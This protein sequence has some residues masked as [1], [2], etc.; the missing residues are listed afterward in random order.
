MKDPLLFTQVRRLLRFSHALLSMLALATSLAL[1]GSETDFG[2]VGVLTKFPPSIHG[3]LDGVAQFTTGKNFVLSNHGEIEGSLLVP[4][5][6]SIR[7]NKG[8]SFFEVIEGPGSAEPSNYKLIFNRGSSVDTVVTRIDPLPLSPPVQPNL[9][10]GNRSVE[11]SEYSSPQDMGDFATLENLKLKRNAGQYEIPA[12]AYGFFSVAHG[13]GIVFGNPGDTEPAV[14]HF[15]K[16]RFSGGSQLQIAGPVVINVAEGFTSGAVLGNTE[17]PE[18][19]TMNIQWGGLNIV[20]GGYFYGNLKAPNGHIN[21]SHGSIL[22]GSIEARKLHVQRHGHLVA[23]LCVTPAPDGNEAPIADSQLVETDEDMPVSVVLTASDPDGDELSYL[24]VDAPVNGILSGVAPNFEYVPNPN[25]NGSDF[26]TFVVSDGELESP[27]ALVD[28]TI[29]PANDAPEAQSLTVEV[30]EDVPVN[31]ELTG[32]DVENDPLTFAIVDQPVHGTLDLSALPQVVY[33]PDPDSENSD[34][35]TYIVN[36]G[37]LDSGPATVLISLIPVN[38]APGATPLVVDLH[39]DEAVEITLVGTDEEGDDLSFEIVTPPGHGVLELIEAQN[40]IVDPAFRYIPVANFNG[41]DH[42]TY[43]VYD[44]ELYSEPVAVQLNIEPVNDPPFADERSFTIEEDTVGTLLLTASDVDGDDLEFIVQTPPTYGEILSSGAHVTSFPHSLGLSNAVDYRPFENSNQADAFT[45][46]VSDGQTSSSSAIANIV[47]TPANDPPV[48]VAQSLATLEDTALDITLAASDPENDPLSFLVTNPPANGTLEGLAPHLT[49]IPSE[50]FDE[51]DTF[52]FVANDGELDSEPVTIEIEVQPVNDAPIVDPVELSLQEDSSTVVL[53][54][55]SDIES[56]PEDLTF[57]IE[58]LPAHGA[59]ELNGIALSQGGATVLPSGS[60]VYRP[61]EDFSD[62]DTFSY[63]ASD[64]E[65][66]SSAELVTLFVI[67]VNDPPFVE[68]KSVELFED[69]SITI[70]LEG[71]DIDGDPLT[72]EIVKGPMAG[73]I[74]GTLPEVIYTP[75]PNVYGVDRIEYRAFDGELYSEIEEYEFVVA[76]INDAPFAETISLSTLEDSTLSGQLLAIDAEGDPLSFA[77]ETPP[78][79]GSVSVEANGAFTYTPDAD[80]NGPDLFTFTVSDG[81]QTVSSGVVLTVESVN[82]A[83]T[84]VSISLSVAENE[85]VSLSLSGADVDGDTLSFTIT[86]GPSSGS[87][88]VDGDAIDTFPANLSSGSLI[89]T[90]NG[91]SGTSDT[92]EFLA[93]DGSLE[94]S[95]ETVELLVGASVN[96][97]PVVDA[98]DDQTLF[99]RS[100]TDLSTAHGVLI[101]CSDE[102]YLSNEGFNTLPSTGNFARNLLTLFADGPGAQFLAYCTPNYRGF[103]ESEFLATVADEG[104]SLVVDNSQTLTFEYL[105]QFDAVFVDASF[106][107]NKEALEEYIDQ[108]GN[109]F[110]TAASALMSPQDEVDFWNPFLANYGMSYNSEWNGIQAALPLDSGNPLSVGVTELHYFNGASITIANP[111]D[112]RL[113]VLQTYADQ[114]LMVARTSG[115]E[116]E[117]LLEGTVADDGLPIGSELTS[118]WSLAEGPGEV[119]LSHPANP[120]SDIG[121]TVPGSYTLRLQAS[122]GELSSE[123]EATVLVVKNDPPIVYAGPNGFAAEVET[124]VSIDGLV[125]DDGFP[126]NL[127]DTEWALFSGP[128]SVVFSDQESAAT[129]VQFSLP[130]IYVLDL[131]ADDSLE[132]SSDKVEYRIGPIIS[133]PLPEGI[134]AWWS[135]NGTLSE[136]VLGSST[137]NTNSE[138]NFVEGAVSTALAFEGE[139]EGACAVASD[140]LDVGAS[141][142]GFTLEFWMN[143]SEFRDAVLVEWGDGLARGVSFRQWWLGKGLYGFL[144]DTEGNEHTILANDVLELDTWQHVALTYDRIEGTAR[145]YRNAVL[146]SELSLGVITPRTEADFCLGFSSAGDLLFKGALD[147]VSLYKRPLS[148]EEIQSIYS[149]G[150][151]GKSP[152]GNRAPVVDVGPDRVLSDT[153]SLLLLAANA[154]DEDGPLGELEIAWTKRAGPGT[155]TFASPEEPSTTVQFS[156]PGIYV[157]EVSANDGLLRSTDTVEIRVG[158]TAIESLSGLAVWWPLNGHPREMVAGVHNLSP[159]GGTDYA[160]AQVSLGLEFDGYTGLAAAKAGSGLDVG[161]SSEGLTIELWVNPSENRDTPLVEWASNGSY[162]LSLRQ[163]WFGE[164]LYGFFKDDAGTERVISANGIMDLGVWQH[165]ALSYDRQSGVARLYRN[166]DEVASA[167]LGVFRP[168]TDRD[169]VV[170]GSRT[171]NRFFKGTLDEIALYGRV[172]SP[173]EIREVYQAGNTGRAP[174]DH[175]APIV[176]AGSDRSVDDLSMPL[177]LVATVEDDDPL[178]LV[179]ISWTVQDGPGS[180]AFASPDQRATE[181]EF[182]TPGIYLLEVSAHDGLLRS[183]DTLEVRVEAP[184]AASPSGLA[185]W[186]PLNGDPRE[187]IAGVHNFGLAGGSNYATGRIS[188]GLEL[189]GSTGRA[190]ALAGSGLDV[191][192]SPDGL[193]V[194]MWVNPSEFRDTPLVE[195]ASDG[196]YGVS[197]RQ[198]WFGQGLY[199][200]LK[201]A[202]G[203]EHVISANG[204]MELGVWQHVAL[205][206][207]AQSG[208]ARLYRNGAEIAVKDVGVF[209]PKTDLDFVAGAS[210]AEGR[211]FK[212]VLD[213]VSLYGRSLTASEIQAVYLAGDYGKAP[214]DE[215]LNEAPIVSAGPNITF[216][217]PVGSFD[218]QGQAIDDDLPEGSSLEAE[219]AQLSGPAVTIVSPNSLDTRVEGAGVGLY[220]FSLSV[221]D[222]ELVATDTVR[223]RIPSVA[224]SAPSVSAGRDAVAYVNEGHE[225]SGSIVDDG[226]PSGAS[227]DALW[228]VISGPGGVVFTDATDPATT[229]VFDRPGVYE[230]RL[231]ASDTEREGSDTLTVSVYN[232][233]SVSLQLPT[234]DFVHTSNGNVVFQA[235]AESGGVP[236]QVVEFF[237]NGISVGSAPAFPGTITHRLTVGADSLG[238]GSGAFNAYAVATDGYGQTAISEERVFYVVDPAEPTPFAEIIGPEDGTIVT[239]PT[240]IIGSA[241]S[242]I[243][244]SYELEY[245]SVDSDI[246]TEIASGTI[247]VDDGELGVLDPTGMLN[248]VYEIR[249]SATDRLGRTASETVSVVV[250]G[251]MKVGNLSLAFE[252]LSL[253]VSGIPM[254]VVR[255][256][257]SRDRTQGDFGIG[258]QMAVSNMRIQKNRPV[259]E[260]WDHYPTE[261]ELPIKDAN[262]DPVTSVG[263]KVESTRDNIVTL[264]LPDDSVAVFKAYVEPEITRFVPNR[265]PEIYYEALGDTLGALEIVGQNQGWLSVTGNGLSME[266]GAFTFDVFNPTLY[267]YTAVDGTEYL[268]DEELGL[269]SIS[270]RNGNELSIE[271]NGISHS[272]GGS[273]DFIRDVEGRVTQIVDPLGE[274]LDY[275]YDTLGRLESFSNQEDE[276][277]TFLYQ[278]ADHPYYLTDILDPNGDSVMSSAYDSE[279]RLV[280]Q[281]DAGGNSFGFVH[282]IENFQETVIDRLGVKTVHNYNFDGDVVLTEIFDTSDMLVQSM[283]Y[284]YDVRGNEIRVIDSLG[285]VTERTYDEQDNLLSETSMVTDE[286]G[287][288]APVTTSYSYDAFGNPTRIADAL[289]KETL[290]SYDANGNL[291]TQ[292][293]ALGNVTAFDY[294]PSGNLTRIIDPL[295]SETRFTHTASG[296]PE[297]TRVYDS[298]GLLV[299]YQ[300]TEYDVKGR[301]VKV[302][303]YDIPEGATDA[304]GMTLYRY[305]EYEY[306]GADR[307]VATRVRDA[308]SVILSS[309]STTYDSRGLV[310]SQID[311]LGRVMRFEY[312]A[313]GNRTRSLLFNSQDSLLRSESWSYDAEGRQIAYTDPAGRVTEYDYDALGRQVSVR[314]IGELD[315]AGNDLDPSDNT[316]TDTIYDAIGRVTATVDERGNVTLFEYDEACGCS[317]RRTKT[318]DA[319]LNETA[320]RYDLNGN[321]VAVVDANGHETLFEYDALNRPTRTTFHDGTF[322]ETVYDAL[323]RKT[324]TI[325]SEGNRIDFLYDALG[326]LV[327]VLQP[328]PEVGDPRPSTQYEYDSRGN[329]IEQTDA[330]GRTTRYEYDLLGRRIK[331]ILPEGE[332][333]TYQ[334]DTVGNLIAKVDFAGYTTTFGY[335]DMNRLIEETADPTHPSISLS[336]SN[337]LDLS[338]APSRIEHTY[339]VTG[340]RTQSVI[341]DSSSAIERTEH[342]TYDTRNRLE[343]KT[344]PEGALHYSYDAAGNLLSSS[345]A[346]PDGVDNHYSYDVLNRL[347]S[348]ND[349]RQ[350][351]ALSLTSYTYDVVGNL[352]TMDYGNGVRHDYVYDTLNR[353]TNLAIET[354]NIGVHAS[355]AYTLSDSGNRTRVTESAGRTTDYTYD[356][357]YRLTNETITGDPSGAN[358]SVSYTYDQ[359]GNRQ[360][361]S[362]TLS[363][364]EGQTFAYNGNDHLT[365]DTLGVSPVERYDANGNTTVSEDLTNDSGG[366]ATDV[367]DYRN[368]LI[369]RTKADGSVIDLTYDAAGNRV[370]KTIRDPSFAFLSSTSYIVD[371]NNHTGFAQVVEEWAVDAVGNRALQTVYTYGHDLI[372]QDRLQADPLNPGEEVMTL[373]FYLY[374]GH[375]TVRQL[376][377]A[378]GTITDDYNYDAFGIL[379][380]YRTLDQSTGQL[381]R[382]SLGEGGSLNAYLY[383]GEQYDSDLG[384]Y[385]LRARYLNTQT[386]RFHT[387]DTYEGRNGDPLTL[388][389]YLYTHS[390]PVMNVDPSGNAALFTYTAGHTIYRKSILKL[391]VPLLATAANVALNVKIYAAGGAL[392]DE[393]FRLGIALSYVNPEASTKILKIEEELDSFVSAY[394]SRVH[395]PLL[396]AASPFTITKLVGLGYSLRNAFVVNAYFGD[397]VEQVAE[398]VWYDDSVRFFGFTGDLNLRNSVFK[399][400]FSSFNPDNDI[401]PLTNMVY[402]WKE[403]NVQGVAQSFR[404]FGMNLAKYGDFDGAFG[405]RSTALGGEFGALTSFRTREGRFNYSVI[406]AFRF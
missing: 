317:G 323:G 363:S 46:L 37:E 53:L 297:T 3:K 353:L 371:E 192:S 367:Y 48:G 213:E 74:S 315:E 232:R 391:A 115:V 137:L 29:H 8:C 267:R 166:G 214:S 346:N 9:P 1:Y 258:W 366:N 148:F 230:L 277:F 236:V 147:E 172:L 274:T 210:K 182:T 13:S 237:V 262:G 393:L 289:G 199:G 340:N 47:I 250:E 336:E 124:P 25:E 325:D 223:V 397:I 170:G 212:G 238:G 77:Q 298:S 347:K 5:S 253:P 275:A 140:Q 231:A 344:V 78:V 309:T 222:T 143:P 343:S 105:L 203:A 318:I 292:T 91:E 123:D 154:T 242:E 24:I 68:A 276:T 178:E 209:V 349:N 49:Y 107:P 388:H 40:P 186:W 385:F 191:G 331:R 69:E 173:A 169:F 176:W 167:D 45:Y 244:E 149:A 248:G 130:G 58:S 118:Q 14:Y 63:S 330:E 61:D 296:L 194:E 99:A 356:N 208:F 355:Y 39:E 219:W 7:R 62:T 79:F 224:N 311:P 72:F 57:Q 188:L 88:T 34:S 43:R 301:Q 205:T 134:A 121:F 112:L 247:S 185:A 84:A 131:Q 382:R 282:D 111:L 171:E 211:Y 299:R 294:D 174:V 92:F 372:S 228:N 89:Y 249:I 285:Y 243:L 321:Q 357:L 377:D 226:L 120:V 101:V 175:K 110:I 12:G 156:D 358:G 114:Y 252:D 102:W 157:L 220:E 392:S 351:F 265:S 229:V 95:V 308:A 162:G 190:L 362:S 20:N 141:V 361:R 329:Q 125:F 2:N 217:S 82:D 254:Q 35:F 41:T 345:S 51:T 272:S 129:T 306:D 133:A 320:Y 135:F 117:S 54:A 15:Q 354:S 314:F 251:G 359:V 75:L 145:L 307:Q 165:V 324:A 378:L 278:N 104:H 368:R 246:W 398:G 100:I 381:V 163:W 239:A 341:R 193:T 221:S 97:A 73:S 279:G 386:G 241:S 70:Q 332:E 28:L 59:L 106:S 348:V 365:T 189:D 259:G 269:L 338:H 293:D 316:R 90:P 400:L 119:V 116:V 93:S 108:G 60:L 32:T 406:G 16:L 86:T 204:V 184:G 333:E 240:S 38:D 144:V 196:A 342:Y 225:L 235:F 30:L 64:G 384:M 295:G 281:T 158:L 150:D 161:A 389:K 197:L 206:Y 376:A 302:H 65:A 328:A 383:T 80:Y 405:Y 373:A 234:V 132:S 109:V 396:F 370:G 98:G 138:P 364:V 303:D 96:Q 71:S 337:G 290:F 380:D 33:Q 200:F 256:Y 395:I 319:L 201:D 153:S 360:T 21:I 284:D 27:P 136:S 369:R 207:D 304:S 270:D 291:E 387:M 83:P 168:Q 263:Y 227:L 202:S 257:D 390:N 401:M 260:S 55:A 127:L 142:S 266:S 195:W 245:R 85:S 23:S 218:L 179:K 122:D 36:D 327:E 233:V 151:I 261:I 164:G 11:L 322:T 255:S 334:Y 56:D 375:G 4:G 152:V 403:R 44:G 352:D 268:I 160:S 283:A 66:V 139:T 81:N 273:I 286:F 113:T 22:V 146:L 17:H 215:P 300:T 19:L 264:R 26:F 335:D 312:N 181:A 87:L 280:S 326:R 394:N 339:D 76:P 288:V 287:V 42:F 198:W 374:D 31:I 94:S 126:A 159:E 103:A 305:T 50:D 183:A 177:D 67:P 18:L 379:L 404:S 128:G 399:T 52:S 216:S 310:E 350:P 402:D 187:A 155:V 6:P 180:V 271:E 10:Q 313:N